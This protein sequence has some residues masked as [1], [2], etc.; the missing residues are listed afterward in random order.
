MHACARLHLGTGSMQVILY[1][2]LTSSVQCGAGACFHEIITDASWLA[3]NHQSAL[4]SKAYS[5]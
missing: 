5:L 3:S 4:S 1:N 2:E